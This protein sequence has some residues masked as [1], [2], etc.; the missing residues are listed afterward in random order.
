MTTY[1]KRPLHIPLTPEWGQ[2]VKTII[3]SENGRVAYQNKE[4]DT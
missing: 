2:K 4:N 3:L 1:K